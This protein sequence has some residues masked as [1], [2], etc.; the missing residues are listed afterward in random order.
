M[1][2]RGLPRG[3]PHRGDGTA[4]LNGS[5]PRRP[6]AIVLPPREGFSPGCAGAVAHVVRGLAFPDDLVLGRAT[7]A[8]PFPDRRF[9][10]VRPR[11]LSLSSL[12]RYANGVVHA[13]REA[14]R[15][16][17]EPG[18]IEV[19]NRPLVAS[20]LAR[21]MAP[22]P[23]AL[24]LHN[25]P[26]SM[27]GLRS[28]RARAAFARRI[29]VAAVSPYLAGRY[30]EGPVAVVPNFVELDRLPPPCEASSRAHVILFVGRVV[31]DKGADL[32]VDA[33]ARAMPSLPGWRAELIGADRFAIDSAD[34]PYLAALRP[35]AR[36]AGIAMPGFLPRDAVLASMGRAAIVVV[37]SRWQ[38]P[39]GL[40]ALE[41]MA[42]GA[43]LVATGVG[44]LPSVCG[45]GAR[46]V[47]PDADAIV[48]AI[49]DLAR[50]EP[51][52]HRLASRGRARAEAFGLE[53]AR[54]RL[55]AFRRGDP[56]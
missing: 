39:F 11:G 14:R 50:D 45:D 16:G 12:G 56:P 19:H 17:F 48:A 31:A 24:F 6:V 29:R 35:R 54:R 27:R 20:I 22:L 34:T 38:E 46:L 55:E 25:D 15:T 4:R 10:P 8:P 9:R 47:P 23:V 36:D 42:S 2:S 7:G 40:V 41:A 49:L 53:Q 5:D 1:V 51:A 43:A 13:L 32:F 37:P 21:A 30:G 18:A 3:R 33:V 52:R 44:A 26:R 28:A